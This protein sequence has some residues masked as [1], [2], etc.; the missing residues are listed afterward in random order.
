MRRAAHV[1]FL[2]RHLLL[3]LYFAGM[4]L[5][6]KLFFCL[7]C[8]TI[9]VTKAQ[10][11][12]LNEQ[13][14]RVANGEASLTA[15]IDQPGPVVGCGQPVTLTATITGASEISWKRN[16]EFITGATT[17]TFVANQS[18]IYTVVVVSLLCQ[19]ESAP[20]EVI[21]ESPLSASILTPLGTMA[22]AGEAVQLQA[23]GGVAQWQWYRNGVALQDGLDEVYNA[24]LPGSYVVVGNEASVCASTSLPVEVV[25]HPLP[26][27]LLIWNGTPTICAGDSLPIAAALE[28][29]EQATWYHDETQLTNAV[30]PF[31]ASLAGEYHA[32]VTNTLTG[33]SSITNSLYLEVLPAQEI[34][35]AALGDTSF[36]EGQSASLSLTS[37]SGSLEWLLDGLPLT[38]ENN[39][40]L[41]LAEPGFYAARV[42]DL[43]GCEALSNDQ[44]MVVLPLPT[45]DVAFEGQEVLCGESDTVFVSVESGN[46]YMWYLGD[47]LIESANDP[48]LAIVEPGT[49]VVQLT[50]SDGCVAVS[51]P[52]TVDQFG[53]PEVSLEPSGAINLCAGQA[54]YME[55]IAASAIQFEWYLNGELLVGESN[56]YLEAFDAG[57]FAVQII[58]EN[59]CDAISEPALL[60]LLNVNTPII[61]D[62]GVTSQGQLLLTDD[63]AGHQWYLNGES[64]AGATGSSYLA[65][66]DG[67]YSVISIEDVCES[68]L[69]DGFEVVLGGVHAMDSEGLSVYPNPCSDKLVV[70]FRQWQGSGYSVY[71]ATG[72]K[73]FCGTATNAREVIDVQSW[74]TG[75]YRVVTERGESVQ[76]S[77]VR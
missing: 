66:E 10:H 1:V 21:L 73:V 37:G 18:G 20:V 29:V 77:V 3:I 28:P 26:E 25:I 16:G 76:I 30:N 19:L 61:T 22:C 5:R 42:T 34:V 39:D 51:E 58:D 33:C 13:D 65:T 62:G 72:R 4:K 67:V 2:I 41:N 52:A 69:S 71:D 43:N 6:L 75:M 24:T 32:E 49:Y 31:Y 50:S 70:A 17:N 64:I 54:Q 47:S 40:I 14:V 59:G 35:I 7:F 55:A 23:S 74:S 44:H 60:Q 36:C 12:V 38:G 57:T 63:A 53:A 56:N 68:G 9:G 46:S 27:V 48:T 45:T 11:V 8:A 15:V